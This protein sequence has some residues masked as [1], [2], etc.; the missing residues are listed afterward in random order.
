MLF[1]LESQPIV[2]FSTT[3]VLWFDNLIHIEFLADWFGVLFVHYG[4]YQGGVFR[5]T[6]K[7]NDNFPDTTIVPVSHAIR[8]TLSIC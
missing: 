1:L 4:P 3:S 2:S 7:F 6:I 8:S 5:F